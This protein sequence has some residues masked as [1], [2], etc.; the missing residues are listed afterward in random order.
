M[1]GCRFGKTEKLASD[2]LGKRREGKGGEVTRGESGADLA[3]TPPKGISSV[4]T[5]YIYRIVELLSDNNNNNNNIF[6]NLQRI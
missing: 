2:E 1:K 6:I 5:S 4:I 3:T